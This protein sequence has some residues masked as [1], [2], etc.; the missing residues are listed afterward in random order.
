MRNAK[1]IQQK[2]K[3]HQVTQLTSTTYEVKSGSSGKSYTVTQ[4]N[5]G[6]TCSCEWG[7]Y[8]KR[9]DP[10]SGCSHTV[11]VVSYLASWEGR[12]VSPWS[13]EEQARK[14]HKPIET[15]LGDNLVLTT[16]RVSE[17]AVLVNWPTG[18]II[19]L[20]VEQVEL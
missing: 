10:R 13:S 16:R 18:A 12:R 4:L 9:N 7:Q 3:S 5:T 6:F 1:A 19:A 17:P 11:S 2:S 8:R 15:G 20:E 14:Q